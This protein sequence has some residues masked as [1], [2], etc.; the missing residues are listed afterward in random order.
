ME[1]MKK[2]AGEEVKK[3]LKEGAASFLDDVSS[4]KHSIDELSDE[5]KAEKEAKKAE[6]KEKFESAKASLLES[7]RQGIEE[8]KSDASFTKTSFEEVS[9]EHKAEKAAKKEARKEKLDIEVAELKAS[10]D[11]GAGDYKADGEALIDSL[12][13]IAA[14][15]GID[16]RENET[17]AGW[18]KNIKESFAEGIEEFRS[19]ASFTKDTIEDVSAEYKASQDMKKHENQAKFE[20]NIAA[21]KESVESGAEAF[22]SDAAFTKGAVDELSAEHKADKEAKKE[23][24]REKFDHDVESMKE[25]LK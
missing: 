22:R 5:R 20:E 17:V 24:K 23:A 3:S 14:D 21:V 2:T 6:R 12:K 4:T 7:F 8:F 13:E 16:I 15:A 1:D 25:S 9:S 11:K 10:V 18:I 19:D